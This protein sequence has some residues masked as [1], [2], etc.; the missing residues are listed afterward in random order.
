MARKSQHLNNKETKR[1]VIDYYEK[2]YSQKDIQKITRIPLNIIRSILTNYGAPTKSYRAIPLEVKNIIKLLI[3]TEKYSYR[4]I[5]NFLDISFHVVREV[6]EKADTDLI[7]DND[8]VHSDVKAE[9][10]EK[11]IKEYVKGC[12]FLYLYDKYKLELQ[13]VDSL[14]K[15]IKR[16]KT[17][18]PT[19]QKNLNKKIKNLLLKEYPVNMVAKKLNI[20]VSLVR[21]QQKSVAKLLNKRKVIDTASSEA[22]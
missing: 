7:D 21:K 4:M 12:S 2:G 16:D 17:I 5:S 15:E 19:H 9:I 20:S 22:I 6:K 13:H 10:C 18:L 14:V 11:F 1:K 8:F 3:S